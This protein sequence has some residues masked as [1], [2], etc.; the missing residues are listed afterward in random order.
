MMSTQNGTQD[1]RQVEYRASV[2]A[3]MAARLVEVERFLGI[4]GDRIAS[5]LLS[6]AAN[7]GCENYAKFMDGVRSLE[8]KLIRR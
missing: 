8:A 3:A 2:S 1:V 6:A 5:Q 4:S 7:V